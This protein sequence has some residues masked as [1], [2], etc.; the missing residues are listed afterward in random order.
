VVLSK[1]P[2]AT[3]QLKVERGSDTRT[4]EVKL[5]ERPNTQISP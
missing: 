4:I 2:G 1:K 3:V 5:G